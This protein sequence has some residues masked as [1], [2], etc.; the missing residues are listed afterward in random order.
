MADRDPLT[1][2]PVPATI[3]TGKG[4]FRQAAEVSGVF[5]G[6]AW[7][8]GG[9]GDV[10]GVPVT[11][12]AG[13]PIEGEGWD[14]YLHDRALALAAKGVLAVKQGAADWVNVHAA[15]GQLRAAAVS[16]DKD[17]LRSPGWVVEEHPT[18]G[19]VRG[20]AWIR[21]PTAGADLPA[22]RLTFHLRPADASA[23]PADVKLRCGQGLAPLGFEP[24]GF[25]AE[26]ELFALHAN[27]A[28]WTA[29]PPL[30][31]PAP[32]DG[33]WCANRRLGLRASWSPPAMALTAEV[34][35]PQ[36]GDV[37]CTDPA[38]PR[39]P[40]PSR[41]AFPVAYRRDL[42]RRHWLPALDAGS[43]ARLCMS[44]L[45][46]PVPPGMDTMPAPATYGD[47][48]PGYLDYEADCVSLG[49]FAALIRRV[50]EAAHAAPGDDDELRLAR[51]VFSRLLQQ[52]IYT[53]D[54]TATHAPGLSG[55]ERLD[56]VNGGFAALWQLIG[57]SDVNLLLDAATPDYRVG[58]RFGTCEGH[59]ADPGLRCET[60]EEACTAGTCGPRR[61]VLDPGRAAEAPG[62]GLPVAI[63][64]ALTRQMSWLQQLVTSGDEAAFG[65]T[66]RHALLNELLAQKLVKLAAVCAEGG[67]CPPPAWLPAYEQAV[68]T[69]L[70][71]RTAVVVAATR[72]PAHS[73]TAEALQ[74]RPPTA[75]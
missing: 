75:R 35:M 14:L 52:W 57:S 42:E 16:L 48:P 65:P 12:W 66:L 19:A 23:C 38:E 27:V 36:A 62:L 22:M 51:R 53:H 54:F 44:E 68:R 64:R 32:I 34:L 49:H 46:R 1:P 55:A 21:V 50:Q 2:T 74:L 20:S 24:G 67:G 9:V 33:L 70:D 26:Q 56:I 18:T 72:S 41:G 17:V 39:A 6:T 47:F 37:F 71:A 73:E 5:V 10:V 61:C 69:Y 45:R 63:L 31:A 58:L 60:E 28:A 13:A 4:G 43:V 15:A 40:A 29:A 8:H 30:V 7:L 11:A 59:C 25:R 3:D